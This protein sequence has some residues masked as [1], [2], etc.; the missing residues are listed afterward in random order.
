MASFRISIRSGKVILLV[1]FVL[2]SV[3][4]AYAETI[5]PTASITLDGNPA[6]WSSREVITSPFSLK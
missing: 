2:L 1:L 5:I 6:D 4:T 3:K